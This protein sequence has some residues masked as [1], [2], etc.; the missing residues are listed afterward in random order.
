MMSLQWNKQQQHNNQ[1]YF[2][3]AQLMHAHLNLLT[4]RDAA[5][6]FMHWIASNLGRLHKNITCLLHALCYVAAPFDTVCCDDCCHQGRAHTCFCQGCCPV[7]EWKRFVDPEVK[8]CMI[9]VH[10]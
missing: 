9:V 6:I 4:G 2:M 7:T 5:A 3:H 1:Y 8:P 10:H